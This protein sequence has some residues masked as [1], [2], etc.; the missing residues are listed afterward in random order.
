VIE[1][2]GYVGDLDK[3]IMAAVSSVAGFGNRIN[4]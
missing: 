3:A 1:A 2:A 4:K